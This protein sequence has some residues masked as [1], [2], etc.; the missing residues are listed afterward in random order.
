MKR[1]L[2][3]ALLGLFACTPAHAENQIGETVAV[4]FACKTQAVIES[5]IDTFYKH[6]KDA[7]T[8]QALR[9]IANGDCAVFQAVPLTINALGRKREPIAI[10]GKTVEVQAIGVGNAWTV[11][12]EEIPGT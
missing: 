2:C 4:P 8:E 9:D 11:V 5:Q 3:A 12:V 1:L 7:V 6:G 10:D